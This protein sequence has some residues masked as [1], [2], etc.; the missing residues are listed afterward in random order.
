MTPFEM[1][2]KK[3]PDL[4]WL[5]PF[6]CLVYVLIHKEIRDGKFDA[7]A[8]PGVFMGVSE[9][10]SGYKVHILHT[11]SI[12][13]ARDVRF[14]EDIY[15]FRRNP[16]TD[17]QWMNPLDCPRPTT[18]A[19]SIGSFTDPFVQLD[20][21][22]TQA[23]R[24]A[25][26]AD[27]YQRKVVTPDQAPALKRPRN[28][29]DSSDANDFGNTLLVTEGV[30]SNTFTTSEHRVLT[31]DHHNDDNPSFEKT[32][33]YNEYIYGTVL[34]T[35]EMDMK[36]EMDGPDREKWLEAFRVEYGAIIKTGTFAKMTPEALKIVRDGK[37]KVHLIR[38]IL[39]HKFNEVGKI[40]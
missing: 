9:V 39:S 26:L 19:D 7:V 33:E 1:F 40:A 17:L 18:D 3:K 10:H 35:V 13:I 16:S 38:P 30:E 12:K 4:Q 31:F 34:S 8:T 28:E 29:C 20:Q 5:K 11:G 14:Y 24:D 21:V 25:S 22:S 6:G 36:S 27:L 23:R 37:I 32:H 2:W 15:P